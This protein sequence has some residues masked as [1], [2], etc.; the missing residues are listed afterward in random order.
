[1]MLII[2]VDTDD[3]DDSQVRRQR[4]VMV[5]TEAQYKF[6]YLAVKHYVDTLLRRGLAAEQKSQL[7]NIL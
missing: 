6:V 1:M 4:S 3:K 2:G 7:V 5:Q